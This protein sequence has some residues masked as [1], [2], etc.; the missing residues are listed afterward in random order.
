VISCLPADV[1][2]N[3]AERLIAKVSGDYAGRVT[4]GVHYPYHRFL[5]RCSTRTLMGETAFDVSC[6]VDARTGVASTT[7]AFEIE[8]SRAVGDEVIGHVVDRAEARRIA[9]RYVSYI[10]RNRRKALVV[11]KIE[12]IE[13]GVVYKRFWIVQCEH[14]SD[15]AF[16]V[17]VDAVTGAFHVLGPRP[18]DEGRRQ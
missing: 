5:I 4:A 3:E 8:E 9:E 13:E 2:R 16:R 11:P 12:I 15:P 10:V 18:E 17:M 6:L 7:D 14:P 1:G